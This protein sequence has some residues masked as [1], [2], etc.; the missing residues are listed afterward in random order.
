[1]TDR[2]VPLAHHHPRAVILPLAVSEAGGSLTFTVSDVAGCSSLR[3][4]NPGSKWGRFCR[5][6]LERRVVPSIT[7]TDAINLVPP[8]LPIRLLKV[9]A[10]GVDFDILRSVPAR[11]FARVET[12]I[13]EVV[14]SRC[15][16]LY[17]GQATCEQVFAFM[18]VLGFEP[19]TYKFCPKRGCEVNLIFRRAHFKAARPP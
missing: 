16:P 15:T 14:P 9:D 7:L 12:V 4:V 5:K 8:N 17:V 3:K 19:V 10:Q 1:M 18:K 11:V 6:T 13:L 2:S